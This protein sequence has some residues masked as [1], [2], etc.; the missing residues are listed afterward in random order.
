MSG[1]SRR[2]AVV[3]SLVILVMM[4]LSP[5]LI[6]GLNEMAPSRSTSSRSTN[7]SGVCINE[8][9]TNADGSDQGVFPAGEWVEL[10]NSGSIEVSLENWILEDIGGWVHPIDAGTWVDFDQLTT[11][12]VLTAGSYAI[13]AENE[14]GTLRLNNAGETLYL[15]DAG[16]TVI[17]TATS[18]EASNGVS[19]IPD[20]SDATADWIDSEENTPGAEN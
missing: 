1:R 14:V 2:S 5:I 17:H 16:G 3:L 6:D 19:K 7:C 18:G 9:M 15:K 4:S 8:M 10:H 12:Y 13:I 20:S 11:P